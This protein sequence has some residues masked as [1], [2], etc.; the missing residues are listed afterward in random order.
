MHIKLAVY[1]MTGGGDNLGQ[2]GERSVVTT[3]GLLDRLSH[4]IPPALI[5]P[6]YRRNL[7]ILFNDLPQLFYHSFGFETR[8]ARNKAVLD[9]AFCINKNLGRLLKSDRSILREKKKSG[10]W[11]TGIT[12]II[13]EWPYNSNFLRRMK[14]LWLE[15]D[16][17]NCN[18][19]SPLPKLFA[20][21]HQGP[22]SS[23]E[24][25]FDFLKT[26]VSLTKGNIIF[27]NE[28]LKE[29]IDL[30]PYHGG[31]LIHI[32]LSPYHEGIRLCLKFQAYMHI[33]E[34]LND[35][36]IRSFGDYLHDVPYCL[37]HSLASDRLHLDISRTISTKIGIE[38]HLPEDS[39]VLANQPLWEP[40]LNELT[41]RGLCLEEKRDALLNWPGWS[42]E[43][44]PGK[45][46][47]ITYRF[48]YYL[49]AVLYSDQD[50]EIKGYFG[51]VNRAI[52]S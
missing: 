28:I 14:D 27:S 52:N 38:C 42:Y 31:S 46:N 19:S 3:A 33:P 25:D 2:T 23:P 35:L 22:D 18:N 49:K 48:L 6:E 29:I 15:Y 10:G 7:S 8:L 39:F 45:E 21:L 36:G 43:F 12:K 9:A 17:E 11:W 44:I 51:F 40:V 47:Y 34:F 26:L 13:G 4:F 50:P 32:G 16:M 20:G 1:P 30:L 41:D 37:S 24:H 5:S